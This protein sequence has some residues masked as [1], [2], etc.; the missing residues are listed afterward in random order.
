MRSRGELLAWVLASDVFDLGPQRRGRAYAAEG[1]VNHVEHDWDGETLFVSAMVRGPRPYRTALPLEHDGPDAMRFRSSCSCPMGLDCKHVVAL[2]TVVLQGLTSSRPSWRTV[3]DEVLDEAAAAVP[4]ERPPVPLAVELVLP[5][6]RP[7]SRWGPAERGPRLWVRAVRRG[8]T[9]RWVRRGMEWSRIGTDPYGAP[10]TRSSEPPAG[11]PEDLEVLAELK[12]ALLGRRGYLAS[13]SDA[14]DLH[15]AGPAVWTVLERVVARGMP[16]VCSDRG[17]DVS[18]ADVPAAVAVEVRRADDSLALRT[19]VS[20][21]EERFEVQDVGLVGEPAHGVVLRRSAAGPGT[22]P[23]LVLARLDRPV[24][25]SVRSWFDQ[26]LDL[27]VEQAAVPELLH[28]YLPALA[29]TVPVTSV[30]GSVNIP[31]PARISLRGE[32]TW[33]DDG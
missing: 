7:A 10:W 33:E 8:T 9:G 20:L 5:T 2:G 22:A 30:D 18:L 29:G 11:D 1:R 12:L 24:T 13:S 32:L 25:A 19:G 23:G 4:V 27:R 21:G 16:L 31:G 17:T 15:G 14:L 26:S 6:A 3:L 28:D